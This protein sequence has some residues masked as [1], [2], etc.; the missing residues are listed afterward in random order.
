MLTAVLTAKFLLLKYLLTDELLALSDV[1]CFTVRS[2]NKLY[3]LLP[4]VRGVNLHNSLSL[5]AF[6]MFLVFQISFV[7]TFVSYSYR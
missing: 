2:F 3:N 1:L 4:H 7:G 5:F 6:K